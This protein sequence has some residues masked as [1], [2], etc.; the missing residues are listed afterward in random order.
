[1]NHSRV[2]WIA[3]VLLLAAATLAIHYQVK[4]RMRVGTGFGS[5]NSLGRL[6]VGD[7]APE[8]VLDDLAKQQVALSSR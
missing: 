1:M 4:V 6:S 8:F 3:A 2:R 7:T 5:V